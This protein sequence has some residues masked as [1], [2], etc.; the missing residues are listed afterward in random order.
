M[1][2]E[3]CKVPLTSECTDDLTFQMKPLCQSV[4]FHDN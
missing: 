2:M 4:L 1:I 3:S